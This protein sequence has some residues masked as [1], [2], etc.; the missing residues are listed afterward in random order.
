MARPIFTALLLSF[1]GETQSVFASERMIIGNAK[2][3]SVFNF[4]EKKT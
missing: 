3:V 4:M 2:I 1:V